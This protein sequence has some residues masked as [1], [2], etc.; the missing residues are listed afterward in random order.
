MSR[1]SSDQRFFSS[2]LPDSEVA[3]GP[4]NI[5]GNKVR[6]V[7]CQLLDIAGL[8]LFRHRDNDAP[9][10]NIDHRHS[11]AGEG[12]QDA[13]A[14]C[15]GNLDNIAGAIIMERGDLAQDA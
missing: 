11:F 15:A 7:A 9:A 4:G 2:A 13:V 1:T 5:S 12:E 6:M 10:G 8:I 3:S 14:V